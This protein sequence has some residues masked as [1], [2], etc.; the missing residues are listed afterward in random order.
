MVV[1][2]IRAVLPRIRERRR[3]IEQA[4]SLPP[5][6]VGELSATGIF[7]LG[8]PKALGGDEA[9]PLDAV[10]AIELVSS[11]DGSTGW[12]TMLGIGA[13]MVGGYMPET[14]AREV[15]AEM[16]TPKALVAEPAGAAVRDGS[17]VR[18]SGRWKFASGITHSDWIVVGCVVMRDGQPSMTPRGPEVIHAFLPRTDVQVHDTWHVSGLCGT[19]SNDVSCQDVYVPEGRVLSLFDPAGYRAEPLYQIPVLSIVAPPIAAVA[20]GIARAALDELCELAAGKTPSMSTTP[21]RDKPV[22]HVEVARAE[23]AHGAARSF[24]YDSLDELWQTVLSGQQPSMR[25]RSLCRAASNHAT[26]TAAYVA[27]TA[28]TLA[29]GTSVYNS[30]DLQRHARDADVIT[31][32]FTQSP[33]VWEDAG[34]ALLGLDPL[35]PLF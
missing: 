35:A 5:D 7:R 12:C 30:S 2:T 24:L 33:N 13:G 10:R 32:H 29:G 25:Q 23:A 17:G 1:E 27:R 8:L 6:L 3:E 31:H 20:L 18:I 28:S 34:R 21:L 26:E 22:M 11:A 15:F 19:G 9:D 4:R 16:D 14:G